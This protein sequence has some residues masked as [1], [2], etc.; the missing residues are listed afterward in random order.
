MQ[1]ES[2]EHVVFLIIAVIAVLSGLGVVF[3]QDIIHAAL[4]LVLTLMLTAGVYVLLSAEFLSLVQVLV[5]GGGVAILVLFAVMI[6][7]V[8]DLRE[9]LDGV[10]KPFA[11]VAALAVI[12]V[13]TTMI[14]STVWGPE[15]VT[16][17][18]PVASGGGAS[19]VTGIDA[20]GRDLFGA[21][22]VPFEIASLVLL[23]ALVG[24]IV[25]ARGEEED[26]A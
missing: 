19:L 25:L 5:Y 9:P 12:A 6:T 1:I 7:R 13:L 22:A 23:V 2:T 17:V 21:F 14:G 3:A 26:T 16:D 15:A 11:I 18:I 10:Q 20:I 24:A 8:R 4:F